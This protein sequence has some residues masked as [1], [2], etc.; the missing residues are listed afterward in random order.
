MTPPILFMNGSACQLSGDRQ[1]HTYGH[2]T[3]AVAPS[4]LPDSEEA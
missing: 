2:Q 3:L 1:P 4:T